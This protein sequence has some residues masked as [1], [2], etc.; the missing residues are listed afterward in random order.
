MR[1]PRIYLDQDLNTAL[2]NQTSI[3]FDENAQRHVAQVLRLKTGAAITLFNGQGGEYKAILEQVNRRS[4]TASLT[5]FEPRDIE[6]ALEVTL[7]QGIS[8]GERM[9]YTLQKATELGV[10]HIVPMITERCGVHLNEQRRDKRMQHWHGIIIAAC[11]QSGR[12]YL[13]G[14]EAITPLTTW[15][16]QPR[17]NPPLRLVLDPD[18]DHSIKSL[19]RPAAGVELL[20]GPEGGLEPGE[21]ELAKRHGY[22]AVT[23][24]PRILRT[25]T[26]GVAALAIIQSLW[27]DI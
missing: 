26:A 6:S 3:T 14:I 25:E 17:T 22:Q 9:D 24:G 4:V 23:L 19:P 16:T 5:G 21:I 11:Q 18:A 8:R 1:Q 20:I 12:N 10:Q 2:E 13:P 15:L 27:G 7:A